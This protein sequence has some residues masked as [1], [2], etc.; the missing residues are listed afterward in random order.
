MGAPG[1]AA[2]LTTIHPQGHASLTPEGAMGSEVLTEPQLSG[3]SH[4]SAFPSVYRLRPQQFRGLGW[5]LEVEII[6]QHSRGGFRLILL[7]QCISSVHVCGVLSR[8]RRCVYVRG[9]WWWG[10]GGRGVDKRK[11]L[12]GGNASSPAVRLFPCSNSEGGW[13]LSSTLLFLIELPDIPGE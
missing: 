2:P 7:C 3:L 8:E 11:H 10:A 6:F 12:V 9:G 13:S 1:K 5:L 4:L